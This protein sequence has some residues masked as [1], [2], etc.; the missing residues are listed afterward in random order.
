M[1]SSTGSAATVVLAG[2][3]TAASTGSCRSRRQGGRGETLMPGWSGHSGDRGVSHPELPVVEPAVIQFLCQ[4]NIRTSDLASHQVVPLAGQNLGQN[5][6]GKLRA[7][8]RNM[9]E[10]PRESY[11]GAGSSH[12]SAPNRSS[13]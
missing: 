1:G 4:W 5:E 9:R 3:G 11:R 7:F 13:S 12:I 10:V 8:A 2:H 6:C